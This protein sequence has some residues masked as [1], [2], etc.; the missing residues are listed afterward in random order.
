[1]VNGW[2][3]PGFTH[4]RELGGGG[5]GRVV[6]A[7][8]DV[9]Q[10]EV[11]IKYLDGR[12]EGDQ[13]FLERFRTAAR[14]L[15]QLED[16][17]VVDFFDFVEAENGAAIV[18]E[19]VEG[20]TL[21]HILAAKGPTGPL[22]ALSLLGGALLGLAAGHEHKIVHGAVRP[23]NVMVDPAGNAK[24]T[25]FA[26]VPPGSEAQAGPA[27]AAPEV[28]NGSPPSVAADLYAVTA[29]FF[30]CL[31]GRPPFSARSQSGLAKAHREAPI[32]VEEVPGPLRDLIAH[33]LAKEPDK[34]PA[35]VADF[36]AAV[37]EAA[38]AAYGPSWEAQGRG[39]LA[40]LVKESA[41]APPPPPAKAKTR[42]SGKHPVSAAPRK[43]RRGRLTVAVLAAL[44]IAGAVAGAATL[45]GEEKD[46]P[47]RPTTSGSPQP[48][49]PPP[50]QLPEAAVLAQR[51]EQGTG[52]TPGAAFAFRRS[53][54]CGGPINARGSLS[55]APGAPESYAMT[56]TGSADTR[57][58]A[59]VVLV[60]DTAYVRAGKKWRPLPAQT[61]G[62]PALAAQARAGSS[63]ANVPALL[64]AATVF[65]KAGAVYQGS[66]AVDRLAQ[67]PLFAELA[68]A[69]GARQ[70]SFAVRVDQAGRPTHVWVK[71][72]T[73]AKAQVL[74]TTY[75]GW[76]RKAVTAPR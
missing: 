39:R 3:V 56:V 52:R 66:A 16:P 73:G 41:A 15:S 11:A 59:P 8:D 32:P 42:S 57:K 68:R 29:V 51:I 21:R 70:V 26:L 45:M 31:T 23:A 65:K 33:G 35:S 75:T 18:M 76:S 4:A 9:T 14:R 40:E 50:A 55:L 72:G 6:L 10:T 5:A 74:S 54:C 63:P 53:G 71:V 69:T 43:G 2:T 20:V 36:L 1:M 25:D 61:R 28:W 27:Y 46:E 48:V 19:R 49:T 47:P 7:V 58:P 67:T 24:V 62:Y 60:R 17:N 22:A 13:A 44:L 12:L 30:E 64:K 38:V 37:E 34:R